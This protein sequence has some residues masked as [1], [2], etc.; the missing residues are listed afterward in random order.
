VPSPASG[1]SSSYEHLRAACDDLAV[2]PAQRLH[3]ETLGSGPLLVLL[4]G[5]TQAGASMRQLAEELAANFTVVLPDLP[6]HGRSSNVAATLDEAADLLADACGPATWFGYS[7]GGRHALHVSVRRPEVVQRLAVLGATAGIVDREERT[8]RRARDDALAEHIERIGV[9]AFL[10][11]WLAQPLFTRLP[12]DPADRAIRLQNTPAGLAASL[13]LAGTGTQKPLDAEL[14]VV[15]VPVLAMAGELDGK[16]RAEAAR[17]AR[18]IGPNAAVATVPGAG[19]A[20]HA[21]RPA[22]LLALL[23]SWLDSPPARA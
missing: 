22:E 9:S 2:A 17:L 15:D 10:E 13:R 5:F 19:H 21:E 11:E 14:A 3:V 16:F 18:A 7:M 20:A 8:A 6:G 23:R 12:D 4:H 1:T